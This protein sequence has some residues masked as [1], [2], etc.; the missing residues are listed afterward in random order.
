[1]RDV[2]IVLSRRFPLLEV[3]I[4]PVPV[5]GATASAQITAMLHRAGRSGRYDAVLVPG[6]TR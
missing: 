1:M 2:I 3:E 5:Q 6:G 4:L